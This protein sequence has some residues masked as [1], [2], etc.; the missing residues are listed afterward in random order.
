MNSTPENYSTVCPFLMVE[1]I[2]K[3][4]DFLT[5]VF[6]GTVKENLK[7]PD[8]ITQHGEVRVGDTVIMMG[9]G[10]KDFPSQPSMNYM[11]VSNVDETYKKA[12]LNGATKVM[13]P[14]DRFYG[15]RECGV[16]DFHGNTWWI[17]QHIKNVSVEE[18]EKGMAE[19]KKN[20][21]K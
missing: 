12:L 17:A 19:A 8:G 16:K 21:Q 9:R 2:E 1:D 20:T 4:M 14:A 11:Y 15:V 6:N 5:N 3:Q 13:E 10:S 7:T 18:M